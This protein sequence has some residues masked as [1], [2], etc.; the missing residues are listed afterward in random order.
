MRPP[1]PA[2][3]RQGVSFY[4]GPGGAVRRA[5]EPTR[6]GRGPLLRRYLETGKIVSTHGLMGE[7]RVQP[8]S[9]TPEFLTRFEGFYFTPDGKEFRKAGSVR[10][11]KNMVLIRFEGVESIDDARTL[12]GRVLYI[13]RGDVQLPEGFYFDQDLL[14]L[15]V[16]DFETGE[17]YGTLLEVGHG[18]ANDYYTVERPGGGKALVPAIRD[19]IRLVDPAG[20]RMLI[21][22]L[23]GL[24]DDAD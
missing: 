6:K 9:D 3:G 13:D 16:S 1:C 23:R 5:D 7:V 15:T 17:V 22:P 12:I 2:P 21:T 4:Q 24:F 10:V 8:W 14:G 11:Q 18:T 20:G 19:V